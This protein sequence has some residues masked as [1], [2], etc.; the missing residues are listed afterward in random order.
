ME[1]L[2]KSLKDTGSDSGGGG[3]GGSSNL[4]SIKSRLYQVQELENEVISEK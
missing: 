1:N 2:Q 4:A 3:G